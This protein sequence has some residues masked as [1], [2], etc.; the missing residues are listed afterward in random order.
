[1]SS[2]RKRS[3]GSQA[4]A[5]DSSSGKLDEFANL[6]YS[7]GGGLEDELRRLDTKPTRI[8]QIALSEL[9]P[10]PAQARRVMPGSLRVQWL[11]HPD[12][13]PTIL[14]QWLALANTEATQRGRPALNVTESLR[15]DPNDTL[16]VPEDLALPEMGPIES[17]FMAL[18]QLAA[19]IHLHG[20]ANPIT[21][22]LQDDD[23][24]MIETGE[25]RFLAYNL[26]H[27]LPDFVEGIW[28]HIPARVVE[29]H[30]LWRQAAENGARQDLNAVSMARQLA[31]LLMDIYDE[32]YTFAKFSDM[33]GR[34]WYAQVYDSK[35]YP[36]P[37]GRGAELAAAMGLKSANQ[38]RQYRQLL[39]LPSEVWQLADELNWTE[40]FCRQLMKKARSVTTV[41][42][43]E[44]EDDESV[45]TVTDYQNALVALAQQSAGIIATLPPEI[46]ASLNPPKT[47]K[48]SEPL[49]EIVVKNAD[50]VVIRVDRSSG[51]LT[52]KCREAE[53][54]D[55]LHEAQYVTVLIRNREVE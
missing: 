36:V 46:E 41:T 37:Y 55:G 33:P 20:L 47:P 11:Q 50:M 12:H 42:D 27:N 3:Q 49:G 28:D 53:L 7:T 17:G 48:S 19:S 18:V 21:V 44:G 2:R 5:F 23:T 1:M 35:Q 25:R 38:I 39:A 34:E 54:L 15:R 6:L 45:T 32:R 24:Y 30:D 29:A 43:V 31:L 26:L 13:I 22:T 8:R 16:A 14:E 51:T 4:D 40:Y 10:D 52:L 9:R